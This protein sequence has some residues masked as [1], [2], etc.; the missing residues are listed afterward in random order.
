MNS[1]SNLK[2]RVQYDQSLGRFFLFVVFF[3]P[4]CEPLKTSL[5]LFWWGSI[6]TSVPM[7][8]FI[9]YDFL[10]SWSW[11]FWTFQNEKYPYFPLSL[12]RSSS[13]S[14][15]M[16]QYFLRRDGLGV[17]GF[18]T[19]FMSFCM[20]FEMEEDEIYTTTE[21]NHLD[22]TFTGSLFLDLRSQG[23]V[24]PPDTTSYLPKP[25]LHFTLIDRDKIRF[26]VSLLD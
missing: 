16:Y 23:P 3:L 18:R 24:S 22:F 1:S 9:P 13:S 17:T 19:S 25:P 15:S 6:S 5:K 20:G 12:S 4:S 21:C 2:R 26:T 11:S 8:L 7:P 14:V 10:G